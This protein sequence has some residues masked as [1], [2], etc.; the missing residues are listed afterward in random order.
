MKKTLLSF[1]LIALF[2]AASIAQVEKYSKVKIYTFSQNDIVTLAK[3]GVNVENIE[4]KI[5]QFVIG[6]FSE[7]EQIIIKSAGFRFDVLVPDMEQY[8]ISRNA[9][10]NIKDLNESMKR[11]KRKIGKSITPANFSLGSMGGYHTYSELLEEL[12]EMQA[13]FP[14]LI[15]T[16]LPIDGGLTIEDRPVYWVRIS[17]NPEVEQEKRR[18]L[19]TALTHA[20]EPAG[21]QQMLYQMWYLLENYE[22]NSEI[23]Y[24]VDNLE[25]YFIPCVNPDGYIFNQTNSPS[26]GGMWRKN[27]RNNIDGS[28]GIDL[29]RNYGYNWGYDDLGSSPTG[30]SETYRGTAP[31]SEP[32]TQLIKS[33]VETRNFDLALNN[34]T[35]SDILIYPWGYANETTTD[36]EL[37]QYY[38]SLMTKENGYAY[39]TC[40]QTLNYTAN[41]GSDDWFYGEQTTKNKVLA[42]TPEAGDPADGFWPAANKIEEICAGHT[43]MNLYL[44]RFA[45]MY[46]K[47]VETAPQLIGSFQFSLPIEITCLGIDTPANFTVT[48]IPLTNNIGEIG[49]PVTFENMSLLEKRSSNFNV[50]LNNGIEA[51]DEIRFVLSTSNGTF[52]FNDTITKVFG[53]SEQIVNDECSSLSNWTSSSWDVTTAQYVSPSTSITDSPAGDY[54]SSSNTYISLNETIDLTESISASVEFMAKWSI[55]T[56]WDYAQ[57][58]ASTDNGVTWIPLEGNHTSIGGSYQ[59]EGNPLY[60]GTQSQWVKETVSLSQFLGQSLIFRFKLVADSYIE[61][62][63]FYFDDFTVNRSYNAPVYKLKLPETIQYKKGSSIQVDFSRF[64]T[65]DPSSSVFFLWEG[66]EDI[67]I[68][69]N[70]W[71]ITFQSKNEEWVGANEVKFTLNGNLGFISQTVT[72]ECVEN[73]TVPIIVGQNELFTYKNTPIAISLSDINVVDDDSSFPNDFSLSAFENTNFTVN[74]LTILPETDFTGVLSVPVSVNDGVNESLPFSLKIDVRTPLAVEHEVMLS[75]PTA[76]FSAS[77]QLIIVNLNESNTFSSLRLVDIYG[78]VHLTKQIQTEQKAISINIGNRLPSGIFFIQLLGREPVVKKLMVN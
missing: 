64:I 23:K 40:Y 12:D 19:Y 72:V 47:T 1:A 18:V 31:F 67:G 26:G 56:N 35:Y 61:E 73:A 15:S 14:N 54:L 4:S 57:F 50:N 44:A 43:E 41:G 71:E 75:E 76:Y 30:S 38:A 65:L 78:R 10:L 22:T 27:R 46:A 9:S 16:K 34:H 13:L 20:R 39:G 17:N 62:D 6:E 53:F 24:L 2:S 25:F 7:K 70:A 42:F 51:G 60:H 45:T 66:N 55:E 33:F 77:Q 59:D 3:A 52:A 36:A 21:M 58:E 69:N 32:E 48:L 49:E 11:Q 28:K 63:G 74:E 5:G 68:E 8:Y 29:N 37:L